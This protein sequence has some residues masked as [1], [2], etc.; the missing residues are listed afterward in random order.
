MKKQNQFFKHEA[1]ERNNTKVMKLRFKHGW[2]G[3][4]VYQGLLELLF[5]NDGSLDND[6][7]IIAWEL[8]AEQELVTSILND[9]DLF[10]IV[11]KT[12]RCEKIDNDIDFIL[13]KSNSAKKAAEAR[14]AK[15]RSKK[16]ETKEEKKESDF[17]GY[18]MK[19]EA[20][21]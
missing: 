7:E 3:Y 8:G 18:I 1:N 2:A 19:D 13:E 20:E 17:V 4:G 11:N 10:Y 6:P 12:V 5:D 21:F 16:E 9:F 15:A 14:W